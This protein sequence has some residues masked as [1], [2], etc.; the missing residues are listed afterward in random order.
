ME[1]RLNT[2]ARF[3][4]ARQYTLGRDDIYV[5]IDVCCGRNYAVRLFN[6]LRE[7]YSSSTDSL[8]SNSSSCIPSSRKNQ[9]TKR[10]SI[11]HFHQHTS[12]L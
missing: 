9:H 3:P 6:N 12:S 5:D 11:A 7:F 8:H 10:N 1:P 2:A 4:L